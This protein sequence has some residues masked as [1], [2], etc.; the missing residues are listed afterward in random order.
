MAKPD[1]KT[2]KTDD[3]FTYKMFGVSGFGK[4]W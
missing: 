4:T 1:P 3:I 2:F